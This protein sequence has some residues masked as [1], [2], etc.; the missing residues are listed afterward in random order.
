[1]GWG[2]ENALIFLGKAEKNVKTEMNS[3]LKS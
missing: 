1:M 3:V 2:R